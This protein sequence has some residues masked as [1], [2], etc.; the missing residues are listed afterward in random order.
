VLAEY[1][2]PAALLAA[3]RQLRA[4]GALRLEAYT[5]YPIH[6]LDAALGQRRS[7]LAIAAGIGGLLG[8]LGGYFLQWYLVAYLYPVDLGDRPPHMPL[9]FV[10]ITIEMGFLFGGLTVFFACLFAA[11]LFKLWDPV[12]DAEGFES[13]TRAGFWLAVGDADPAFEDVLRRTAPLRV[14]RF[15]GRP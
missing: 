15:G 11:R 3:I 4:A 9:A 5:P 7:P 13:H 2:D 10:I 14:S 6:E 1:A 8:A 12:F